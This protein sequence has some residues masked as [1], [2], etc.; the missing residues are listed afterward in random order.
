MLD[1]KSR[2]ELCTDISSPIYHKPIETRTDAMF[3]NP[4]Q[5]QTS[6]RTFFLHCSWEWLCVGGHGSESRAAFPYR[7]P[8]F[9]AIISLPGLSGIEER[10]RHLCICH[11][12]RAARAGRSVI[13][14]SMYGRPAVG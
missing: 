10:S 4:G 2:D 14:Q 1:K 5:Q 11:P 7:L 8:G 13:G 12:P 6:E 3:P 9:L